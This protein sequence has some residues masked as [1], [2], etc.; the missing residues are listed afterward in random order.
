MKQIKKLWGNSGVRYLFFGGCTTMVNLMVFYILRKLQCPIH[1]ANLLS[2]ITA[3]VFAYFVNARF[4]FRT[5][6]HSVREYAVEMLKFLEA[7]VLTMLTEMAGVWFLVDYL[8]IWEFVSK[9]ATQFLVIILNYI[10]SRWFVF[11]SGR[12]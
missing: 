8:G 1:F 5:T 10:L 4:V 9:L 12:E 6:C 7:R 11:R 2:I 3:V